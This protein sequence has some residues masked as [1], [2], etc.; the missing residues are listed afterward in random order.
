[1]CQEVKKRNNNRCVK[2]R[3]HVQKTYKS[4]KHNQCNRCVKKRKHVQKSYKSRKHNQ[5]AK[6]LQI[7]KR[8]E[9]IITECVSVQK[10]YKSMQKTSC[11]VKK[12]KLFSPTILSQSKSKAQNNPPNVSPCLSGSLHWCSSQ[13]FSPCLS[14]T[15]KM[16]EAP[17]VR[18]QSL[19]TMKKHLRFDL[20]FFL[21]LIEAPEV[22][23]LFLSPTHT[24]FS[25]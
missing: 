19:F 6:D 10:T 1:M 16:S 5:C 11:S 3:K 13:L 24:H 25:R 14:R 15:K 9:N 20:S 17:E 4:R 22:R 2:K 8:K 23:S 18:S 7:K 21:P 12:S